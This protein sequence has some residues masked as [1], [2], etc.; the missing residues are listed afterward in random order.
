M[1]NKATTV[2]AIFDFGLEALES[3]RN[4]E[5]VRRC[6]KADHVLDK[7]INRLEKATSDIAVKNHKLPSFYD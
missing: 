6:F 2:S 5:C 7:D 4:I 3:N 1:K